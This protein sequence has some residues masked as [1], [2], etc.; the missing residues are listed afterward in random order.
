MTKGRADRLIYQSRTKIQLK[1]KQLLNYWNKWKVTYYNWEKDPLHV[2]LSSHNR[3]CL[4]LM[5]INPTTFF[6]VLFFCE[7]SFSVMLV[8]WNRVKDRIKIYSQIS[9]Y[10]KRINL[11][12]EVSYMKHIQE[13]YQSDFHCLSIWLVFLFHIWQ[14]R[15]K[16]LECFAMTVNG[17]SIWLM[18][19]SFGINTV[20]GID[21]NSIPH[22]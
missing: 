17:D 4:Y 12:S 14:L 9:I 16:V 6:K 20:L 10:P 18:I 5:T 15:V 2:V 8:T 13:V 11:N 21:L 1:T 7:E 19:Y 3:V 22:L